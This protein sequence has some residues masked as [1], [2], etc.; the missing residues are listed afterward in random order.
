M[1]CANSIAAPLGGDL[2][3]PPVS[4]QK[5]LNT[6]QSGSERLQFAAIRFQIAERFR[7]VGDDGRRH[8]RQGFAERCGQ[9]V[10]V[11]AAGQLRPPEL[12]QKVH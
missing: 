10:L 8:G 1:R 6:C 3:I 7:N 2:S 12:N 11:E 4:A 5:S 9:L